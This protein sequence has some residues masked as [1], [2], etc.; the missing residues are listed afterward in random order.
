[1]LTKDYDGTSERVFTRKSGVLSLNNN[2][3][4]TGFTCFREILIQPKLTAV[5]R[6][7]LSKTG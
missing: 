5:A 3:F 1:M 4:K 7:S 2:V 6:L